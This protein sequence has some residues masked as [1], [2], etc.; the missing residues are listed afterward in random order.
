MNKSQ[1]HRCLSYRVRLRPIARRFIGER[2]LKAMDDDWLVANVGASIRGVEIHNH[3]TG[4]VVRLPYD[5]I[6]HFSEDIARDWNGLLH[7]FFELRG[8]LTLS[9][10][11]AWLEPLPSNY[12]K[13]GAS[14]SGTKKSLETRSS[15]TVDSSKM[16]GT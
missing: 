9:G 16:K 5:Q 14:T 1:L 2:E 15:A 12:P 7:G 11:K 4:H 6:H 3:R 13:C 10:P 8:Q